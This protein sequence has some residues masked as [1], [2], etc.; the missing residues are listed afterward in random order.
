MSV[1]L[2]AAGIGSKAIRCA[3]EVERLLRITAWLR[4]CLEAELSV[5]TA[6]TSGKPAVVGGGVLDKW[7]QLVSAFDKLAS[8][9]VRLDKASA[10]L[11]DAMTPEEELEAVRAFI[12]AMDSTKRK[13]FLAKEVEFDALQRMPLK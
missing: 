10:A 4:E 12:R 11:A 1:V 8:A 7:S 13:N 3:E 5:H 2:S 6:T 9:K